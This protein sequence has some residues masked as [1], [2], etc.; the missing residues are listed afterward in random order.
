MPPMPCE[1]ALYDCAF[2][3][4]LV[5]MKFA[6]M[7]PLDRIQAMLASQKV[8]IAMGTLVHLV[9]RATELADELGKGED[10]SDMLRFYHG[11]LIF[12]DSEQFPARAWEA[13]KALAAMDELEADSVVALARVDEAVAGHQASNFAPRI[14]ALTEQVGTESV[15]VQATLALAEARVRDT[16]I[17]ELERQSEQLRRALGQSRLAIA[18]LHDRGIGP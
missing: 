5:T 3:A 7:M 14:A 6:Y 1:R 11:L 4:W 13:R 18:Q 15:E 10:H 17:A 2:I 16:A 8:F 9:A 12:E